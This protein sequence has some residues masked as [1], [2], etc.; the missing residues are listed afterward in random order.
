MYGAN[1]NYDTIK[2]SMIIIIVSAFIT[3][4]LLYHFGFR[5]WRFRNK[6]VTT[7]EAESGTEK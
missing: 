2:Y 7:N 1:P 5:E 3:H 4:L 6:E